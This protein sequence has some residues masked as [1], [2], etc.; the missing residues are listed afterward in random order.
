MNNL[1]LLLLPFIGALLG[2]IFAQLGIT[3]LFSTIRKNK[4]AIDNELSRIAAAEFSFDEIGEK[5]ASPESFQK[6]LPTIELHIDEFLRHKLAKKLPF[7]SMFIGDKTSGQLKAVFMTELS[8]I[9]PVVMKKYV[10]G[11]PQ[12]IDVQGVI[13]SKLSAITPDRIESTLHEQFGRQLKTIKL[14]GAAA[15]LMIGLTNM[16]ISWLLM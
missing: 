11:L 6:I 8:E 7:I 3:M 1:W 14:M 15:G 2:W 5:L 10:Q 12:E 4:P 13:R 16:V 9:F